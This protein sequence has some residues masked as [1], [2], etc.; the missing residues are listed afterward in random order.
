MTFE[1]CTAHLTGY[2]VRKLLNSILDHSTE[3]ASDDDTLDVSDDDFFVSGSSSDEEADDEWTDKSAILIVELWHYCNIK[4]DH[5]YLFK[6]LI[7]NSDFLCGAHR[8]ILLL[9]ESGGL[10]PSPLENKV[11]G[12]IL[13]LFGLPSL[14]LCSAFTYVIQFTFLYQ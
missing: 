7:V 13:L 8:I 9:V 4:A 14:M 5:D 10:S 11:N 6:F 12:K 2:L 3:T 1:I